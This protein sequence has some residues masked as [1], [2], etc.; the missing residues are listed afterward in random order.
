MPVPIMPVNVPSGDEN[1]K[2]TPP[3][4]DPQYMGV[5]YELLQGIVRKNRTEQDVRVSSSDASLMF[6]F[7]KNSAA[8]SVAS[9]ED[10]AVRVPASFDNRDLLRLKALGF[11]AGDDT[12]VVKVTARGK[13]VIKNI[14]LNEENA[15]VSGRVHKPYEEI[16]ADNA[17]KGQIRLALE[18]KQ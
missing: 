15:L 10:P 3:Q 5:N 11:V 17:K 4:E 7:W 18:K 2:N 9:S 16:L 14:V 13:E 6:N 12:D 1:R 8:V